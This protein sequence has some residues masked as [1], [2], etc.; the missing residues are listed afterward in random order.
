MFA[1]AEIARVRDEEIRVVADAVSRNA[2][3]AFPGIA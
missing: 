1:I 2:I 3:D